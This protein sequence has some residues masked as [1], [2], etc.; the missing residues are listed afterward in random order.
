MYR[1]EIKNILCSDTTD[2]E[3]VAF[4]GEGCFGK[5]AQCLDLIEGNMVAVKIHK[6]INDCSIQ[7]E[8]KMLEAVRALDPDK[9]NIVKFIEHFRFNDFSCLAFEMLD[10]S[11]CEMMIARKKRHLRI[12]EIRTV[13]QQLLVALDALKNIGII[14]TDL[15]PDNIMLVNHKDQPFR[16]KLIDFGL[17]IPVRQAKVGKIMQAKAYRAPE[18]VLGHPLSASVD[19]W[20]VGCIM[21][22][23]YFGTSLFPGN[24]LYSWMKTFVHLLKVDHKLL[25]SGKY[26]WHYFTENLNGKLKPRTPEEFEMITCEK[27]KVEHRYFDRFESLEHAVESFPEKE[28]DCD[29]KDREAFLDLIKCCLHPDN[30]HRITPMEGLKHTFVTMAYLDTD[31]KVSTLY[32]NDTSSEESD[33][34]DD[35]TYSDAAINLHKKPSAGQSESYTKSENSRE[36]DA[37]LDTKTNNTNGT[38]KPLGPVSTTDWVRHKTT[39]PEEVPGA[40]V[41]D[42]CSIAGAA[43]SI[44]PMHRRDGSANRDMTGFARGRRKTVFGRIGKI[45][46]RMSCCF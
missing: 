30:N 33:H 26:S 6:N 36:I 44:S 19:M 15:K 5:V 17:A 28:D 21:A 27:P 14:H 12:N 34:F 40:T 37:D 41:L 4:H 32:L 24:C 10:K 38:K 1:L 42:I 20:G 18:V 7:K 43:I 23:M 8:V 25:R 13:T 11:L 29:H 22:Y 9:K 31:N 45:F 2:Y 16:I 39:H 35:S 46:R 3:I